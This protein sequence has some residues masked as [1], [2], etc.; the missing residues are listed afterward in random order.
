MILL[1]Q[2]RV[3]WVYLRPVCSSTL[4]SAPLQVASIHF[5]S[6]VPPKHLRC[7]ECTSLSPRYSQS[8]YPG[9]CMHS[10]CIYTSPTTSAPHHHHH[11]PLPLTLS[12]SRPY[13]FPITLSSYSKSHCPATPA[14]T[15]ITSQADDKVYCFRGLRLWRN[16]HV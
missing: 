14:T 13:S 15:N 4:I 9:L 5:A 7:T 1:T 12:N 10:S 16:D 2:A 6:S 3:T 11:S 8:A